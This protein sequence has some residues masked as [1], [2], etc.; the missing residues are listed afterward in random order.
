M[1][2]GMGN[3]LQPA[4]RR[5]LI[6]WRRGGQVFAPAAGTTYGSAADLR[7]MTTDVKPVF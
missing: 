5:L 3:T 1:L 2:Q 4:G 6:G 7:R